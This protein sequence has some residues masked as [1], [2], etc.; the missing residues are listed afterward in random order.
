MKERQEGNVRRRKREGGDR[1]KSR[2]Q[3]VS[4]ERRRRTV[5][6]A[7]LI[8]TWGVQVD[9]QTVFGDGLQVQVSRGPSEVNVCGGDALSCRCRPTIRTLNNTTHTS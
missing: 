8:L 4:H 9:R 6:E 1:G 3:R 7:G 5:G 2:N